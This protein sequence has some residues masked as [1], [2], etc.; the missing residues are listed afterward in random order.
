[1]TKKE[2]SPN[3][4]IFYHMNCTDGYG[5]RWACETL[6]PEDIAIYKAIGW[7]H[8]ID[9]EL[10]QGKKV[11]F[12]DI[13]P[14]RSDLIAIAEIAE[15]VEVWDHHK[16]VAEDLADHPL[17]NIVQSKSGAVLAWERMCK[18]IGE[19]RELPEILKYVQASDLG[20]QYSTSASEVS[21]V[22]DDLPEFEAMIHSFNRDKETWDFI[23]S[24]LS[25]LI[26]T[27]GAAILRNNTV[28]IEDRIFKN[29]YT[30]EIDGQ[31]IG[32]VGSPLYPSRLGHLLA[33]K[34]G[35]G[36]VWFNDSRKLYCSL[37]SV[38]SNGIDTSEIAK[39]FGGGGHKNASGFAVSV[40]SPVAKRI[41]G[42]IK[43]EIETE[44]E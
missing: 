35:V 38:G 9:V 23:S 12:F 2:S 24:D 44:D 28:N 40:S 34:Y 39:K 42:S 27:D 10:L 17:A 30:I 7:K 36:L 11:F 32:V 15:S 29:H 5:A 22:P 31:C 41:M 19:E 4:V 1:M 21:Q 3:Y 37:R 13:A 20:L 18:E 6:L 43:G 25:R 14:T 33:A 26:Q 8:N 16:S